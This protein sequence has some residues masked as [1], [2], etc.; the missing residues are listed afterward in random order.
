M[1]TSWKS[2]WALRWSSWSCMVLEFFNILIVLY[3]YNIHR[4]NHNALNPTDSDWFPALAPF[5]ASSSNI[6]VLARP[7]RRVSPPGDQPILNE[8]QIHSGDFIGVIRLDGLD[9]VLAFGMGSHTGHT[10]VAL[11]EETW[12]VS[13]DVTPIVGGV[14]FSDVLPCFQTFRLLIYINC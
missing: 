14:F 10:A 11:W 2:T 9:P 5:N 13:V 12:L 3:I 6:F 8:S 1:W 7:R 4:S